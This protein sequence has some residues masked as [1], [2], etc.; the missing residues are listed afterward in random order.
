MEQVILKYICPNWGKVKKGGGEGIVLIV[1]WVQLLQD[2]GKEGGG[3]R[4]SNA[5]KNVYV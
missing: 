3:G 2:A 1:K 5:Y 4:G